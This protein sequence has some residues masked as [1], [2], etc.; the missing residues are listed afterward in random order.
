MQSELK[1]ERAIISIIGGSGSG[2]DTQAKLL[3]EK[4]GLKH[5]SMGEIFRSE[6]KLGNPL[7]AEAATYY[8]RGKWAPDRI[9]TGVLR[10]YV[11]R[12]A[13]EGFIITG[14]P[15]P[16][17]QCVSLANLAEELKLNVKAVVHI[18]VADDVLLARMHSQAAEAGSERADTTDE[19]M[20]ERLKSYHE[21]IKPVLE[22]YRERDLLINIDG[23]PSVEIVHN[24]ILAEL[25]K[26]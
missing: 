20:R 14:Y 17:E 2:K 16:P 4:V 3:S 21:T 25:A 10:A 26:L 12:N 13:P 7:V 15:R 6:E 9:T 1:L 23:S 11:I 5:L 18:E 19:L 22:Y 24:Y 8:N